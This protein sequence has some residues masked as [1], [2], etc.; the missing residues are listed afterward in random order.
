VTV[1]VNIDDAHPLGS[2]GLTEAHLALTYDPRLFRLTAADVHLGSVLA[3]GSGWSV[4]PTI[5]ANTGQIAITL[6]SATPIGAGLGGSLVTIDFH[7]VD[8]G[9]PRGVSRRLPASAPILLVAS[10]S[11]NGQYF[12]TELEDAQGTFTLTP[13]PTNGFDPRI[14][15]VVTLTP[16]PASAA[17]AEPMPQAETIRMAE[18]L[19]TE[20]AETRPGES[21]TA[22]QTG[23]A[24]VATAPQ[25]RGQGVSDATA[26]TVTVRGSA[27]HMVV[28][29]VASGLPIA[30]LAFQFASTPLVSALGWVG[31]HLADPLFQPLV[32]ATGANDPTV[33][34][35]VREVIERALASPWLLAPSTPDDWDCLQWEEMNNLHRRTEFIPF[36]SYSETFPHAAS[37][38]GSLDQY[39]AQTT[40]DAD[41]VVEDE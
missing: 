26:E 30:G 3:A 1:A 8:D 19:Q 5:D 12:A 9:E 31:P 23:I 2:T 18:P 14:D 36:Y 41:Q 35:P 7:Q 4:I 6:S 39:F 15:A 22:G 28:A 25:T 17:V 13:A 40:D 29:I 20:D 24:P 16:S 38:R 11:P 34:S 37:D 21:T 27:A 33:P 10:V 32:R